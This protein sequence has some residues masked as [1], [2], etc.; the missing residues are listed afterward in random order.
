MGITDM[1]LDQL[2]N[3]IEA[4]SNVVNFNEETRELAKYF[5]GK[6][7]SAIETVYLKKRY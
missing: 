3:D 2:D 4:L 5:K 6:K 1:E 7:N